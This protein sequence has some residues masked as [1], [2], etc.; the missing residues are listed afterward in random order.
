VGRSGVVEDVGQDLGAQLGLGPG[1]DV[2]DAVPADP[3]HVGD[4]DLGGADL[5]QDGRHGLG[6]GPAHVGVASPVAVDQERDPVAV[7]EQG[8]EPVPDLGVDAVDPVHDPDG[9]VGGGAW[10][11]TARA[12]RGPSTIT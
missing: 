3:G 1:E 9:G 12:W 11:A 6:R 5:V 8:G 10:L 7:A 4:Q 2:V